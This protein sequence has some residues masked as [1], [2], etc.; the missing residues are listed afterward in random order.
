MTWW[1]LAFSIMITLSIIMTETGC[2]VNGWATKTIADGS[3]LQSGQTVSIV[4]KNGNIVAGKFQHIQT[5]DTD[6]YNTLYNDP[7]QNYLGTK[8]LPKIGQT[9]YVSTLIAEN[10]AWKGTMIGFDDEGL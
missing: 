3:D 1:K 2:S 4:K 6:E 9:V 10:K 5:L 8:I 7:L